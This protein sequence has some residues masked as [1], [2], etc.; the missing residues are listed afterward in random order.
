MTKLWP[1]ITLLLML[2]ACGSEHPRFIPQVAAAEICPALPP[3]PVGP[4]DRSRQPMLD[5]LD[6]SVSPPAP[7]STTPSRPTT[8]TTHGSE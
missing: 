8:T 4:V 6:K 7:S 2:S 5:W 3:L 1:I